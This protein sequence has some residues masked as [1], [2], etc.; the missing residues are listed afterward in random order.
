MKRTKRTTWGAAL[1]GVALVVGAAACDRTSAGE[2]VTP[3]VP[4]S[5][6][7]APTSAS[8]TPSASPTPSAS[9]SVS[10]SAD[11]PSPP[12]TMIP[13]ATGS[14]TP[15][16]PALVKEAEAVVRIYFYESLKAE[17]QSKTSLHPELEATVMEPYRTTLLRYLEDSAK[18]GTTFENVQAAKLVSLHVS[19]PAPKGADVSMTMCRSFRD[20]V[21]VSKDGTRES[22]PTLVDTVTLR[23]DTD[24]KLKIS[25]TSVE[26]VASC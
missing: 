7:T 8:V 13:T 1:I 3:V 23:R 20:V 2:S 22:G 12:S 24:G 21:L 25:G 4:T 19:Q 10:A 6:D 11:L 5:A 26:N 16:S 9:V 14:Q 17:S 18:V 15:N